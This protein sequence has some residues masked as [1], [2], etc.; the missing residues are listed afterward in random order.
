PYL[1]D[2]D[3]RDNRSPTKE[4]DP[5]A[6]T[7]ASWESKPKPKPKQDRPLVAFNRHPDAHDV[8]TGRT[9]NFR[10]MSSTKKWWIKCMRK[11]QMPF[12]VL[13]LAGG[14]GLLVLM[15]LI[16]NV[17]ALTAWVLRITGGVVAISSVYALYHLHRPAGARTPAS[18][19][20]YH[21]FSGFTDLAVLPLYSFG[22]LAV[23]NHGKD[24][25]TLLANQ[26][27][28][29][30]LV[31]AVYYLLISAG[32][33][34]FI[35]LCISG[36]LA[37]MFHRIANM[38]P[39]MNPL[40]DNL[41]ARHKRNKSSV[42]TS[43]TS[44]SEKRLSTP[45]EDR[46]RSGAPYETLSR[47]PSI[48]FMHT[49]TG[50]RDS[51]ASSKRDSRAD[52]PSF[53]RQIEPGNS[54]R[55]SITSAAELKRLSKPPRYASP[56]GSYV[57]VPIHETGQ[58]SPRPSSISTAPPV[59]SPTRAARF[60]EAWYASE[61]LISRTQ[62]RARAQMAADKTSVSTSPSKPRAYEAIT[63]QYDRDSDGDSDQENNMMR[64]DPADISD[65]EDDGAFGIG[66][67]HP[68]PLRS[69][70]TAVSS[71]LPRARTPHRPHRDSTLSEINLNSRAPSGSQDVADLNQNSNLASPTSI[72]GNSWQGRNRDSSIQPEDSFY[73]KPY[74]D[75]RA[76]TPPL[77]VGTA[78]G[79]Q[80][81]SGNDYDLG[82]GGSGY[83][84]YRRNVSGKIAEEGRA[85]RRYSRYSV[86]N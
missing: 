17:D 27:I 57:E 68:N 47:P 61:S 48:P 73:A 74:G 71:V 65:L 84:K 63:Q 19:A 18:S 26:S 35:S 82:T 33:C 70:R 75:L 78:T 69:N 60:T 11:V 20:A 14:L 49:R 2:A 1:Y 72:N 22:V 36:W 50:S 28:T 42:S 38:P 58:Q 85:G 34:H 83:G 77:I 41:T 3:G 54:P 37:L 81:S 44:A 43:Y 15:I 51:M 29:S 52:L 45:L 56:R 53:Q 66:N 79:R 30:V 16:S 7:R 31:P 80:V 25:M 13:E 59:T 6:V 86:L 46:R 40:E 9:T 10:P 23:V 55:N 12:R 67:M 24:W 64:P 62:Q 32:G 8:L 39:D 4:F 76:A 5:K 21:L